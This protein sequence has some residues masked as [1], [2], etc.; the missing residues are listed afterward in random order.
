MSVTFTIESNP[1]GMFDAH[2][3]ATDTTLGPA[4]SLD[5]I[6]A[7][8]A[9]HKAGCDE[10]A[11]YGLYSRAVPDVDDTLDVNV[12]N[13]N[14]RLLLAILGLDNEDLCGILDATDFQGR[15]LLAMA[16]DRDDTG[17][18]PAITGGRVVGQTGATMVDCGLRP[19]YYTDRFA[20]LHALAMEAVRLGRPVTWA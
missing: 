8:M 18:P 15:V 4:G 5:E 2:C 16:S 11:C 7:L 9:A 13:T 17:V 6:H 19:G 14:A 10:C 1:T 20:G 3:Y 12:S